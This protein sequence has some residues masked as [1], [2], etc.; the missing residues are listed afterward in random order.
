MS[1]KFIIENR[2]PTSEKSILIDISNFSAADCP[3]SIRWT[4]GVEPTIT[5]DSIRCTVVRGQP[6]AFVLEFRPKSPGS[7]NLE[8]PIY[9]RDEMDDEL[10]NKLCIVGEYHAQ[11]IHSEH[12]EIY[13]KPV[14]LNT[15][16]ERT[17]R[18]NT[19]YFEKDTEIQLKILPPDRYSGTYNND[20]LSV[21]FVDK[22]IAAAVK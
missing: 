6:C 14:P 17:F 13:L 15:P 18:L 16:A 12:S 21:Q 20:V 10:F 2:D 22:N 8:A 3:F 7:F 4:N 5:A 19:K 9:V 1:D 11:T